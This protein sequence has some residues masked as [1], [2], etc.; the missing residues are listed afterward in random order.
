MATATLQQT[1]IIVSDSSNKETRKSPVEKVTDENRFANFIKADK[2]PHPMPRALSSNKE[3]QEQPAKEIAEKA[4]FVEGEEL[5]AEHVLPEVLVEDNGVMEELVQV[6]QFSLVLSPV[7]AV[8]EE[9]VVLGV[10][11]GQAQV[12]VEEVDQENGIAALGLPVLQQSVSAEEVLAPIEGSV[13]PAQNLPQENQIKVSNDNNPPNSQ[14]MA[15]Q[16]GGVTLSA[17]KVEPTIDLSQIDND[18]T[19]RPVIA[20]AGA[21]KAASSVLQKEEM[22]LLAKT[23]VD[24]VGKE[25]ITKL[26]I[27]GSVKVQKPSM[28]IPELVTVS[29]NL[30][31]ADETSQGKSVIAKLDASSAEEGFDQV[32][33]EPVSIPAVAKKLAS[34]NHNNSGDSDI[35]S[36]DDLLMISSGITVSAGNEFAKELGI[37]EKSVH[38]QV[39][40]SIKE[41]LSIQGNNGKKEITINLFPEKLGAVKVE[42][43]SILGEDGARRV[44]SIKFVAEKRETLEILERSRLELE[45]S[46]KEVTS[47]NEET[48]LEFQMNRDGQGHQSGAY[49]ESLKE[50]DNWMNSFLTF[51]DIDN[52]IMQG[53]VSD[54]QSRSVGHITEDSVDIR[55]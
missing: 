37:S 47:T 28:A 1:Q 49:F 33:S 23:V 22:P 16:D 52:E 25:D 53:Q 21:D 15:H 41:M 14:V 27:S 4:P 9:V 43:I 46:L 8:Q 38:E 7:E 12:Q 34:D 5:S 32:T 13:L 11:D 18:A 24:V 10:E 30:V 19:K 39:A 3:K 6:P 2:K 48:S 42:I 17:E 50:R 54:D 44:E 40:S 31:L 55:V 35:M 36:K 29:A 51:N 20:D 26:D 45:K